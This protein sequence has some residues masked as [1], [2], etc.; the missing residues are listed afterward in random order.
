GDRRA[1]AC[2]SA[3]INVGLDRRVAARVDYL[4][5]LHAGDLCRHVLCALLW[6]RA[7]YFTEVCA[8]IYTVG[9][10]CK[11]RSRRYKNNGKPSEAPTVKVAR[12]GAQVCRTFRRSRSLRMKE[13]STTAETRTSMPK[14]AP[15]RLAK[16][17]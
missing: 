3:E 1:A 10:A 11:A 15:M 8:D 2:S 9:F 13:N 12:T 7:S 14:K 6:S 17:C 5:R 16:S 4:T